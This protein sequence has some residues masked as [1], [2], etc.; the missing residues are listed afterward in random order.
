MT[1]FKHVSLLER[2]M[3]PLACDGTTVD[4]LTA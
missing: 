2:I 1:H 3:L 4:M